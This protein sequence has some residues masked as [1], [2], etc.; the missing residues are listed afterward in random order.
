MGVVVVKTAPRVRASCLG[1]EVMTRVE[2]IVFRA[3]EGKGKGL[4][5]VTVGLRC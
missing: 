5:V 4:K 3:G 1:L 2:S